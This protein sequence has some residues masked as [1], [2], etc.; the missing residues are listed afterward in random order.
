MDLVELN[1]V[2]NGV[3]VI[4]FKTVEALRGVFFFSTSVELKTKGAGEEGAGRE[5][6]D[7]NTSL[8]SILT[9]KHFFSQFLQSVLTDRTYSVLVLQA[10]S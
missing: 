5:I 7:S 3:G 9:L 10:G 1:D 8:P 2:A 6:M 4:L